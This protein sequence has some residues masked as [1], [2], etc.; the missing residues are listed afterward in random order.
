M[1]SFFLF[2][3]FV[4]ALPRSCRALPQMPARSGRR[5]GGSEERRG[6]R[7]HPSP[8]RAERNNRQTVWILVFFFP[9]YF[10]V[11]IYFS[12]LLHCRLSLITSSLVY[13]TSFFSSITE[14]FYV[15]SFKFGVS[16][17]E[18][19]WSVF[20]QHYSTLLCMYCMCCVCGWLFLLSLVGKFCSFIYFFY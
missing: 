9:L 18:C 19:S 13:L 15:S 4:F 12:D 10:S 17:S 6:R 14:F 8:S 5:R 7:P 2:L 11:C 3:L 1:L 16:Y 20:P